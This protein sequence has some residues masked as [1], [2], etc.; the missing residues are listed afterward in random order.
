MPYA[1][2]DTAA[3]TLEVVA[4]VSGKKIRV[5]NYALASTG[6]TQVTWKS[7]STAISGPMGMVAGSTLNGDT[8]EDGGLETAAGEALNLAN[9]QAVQIGGHLRYTLES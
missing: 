5:H 6:T 9:A 4:A 7:G 8:D 2:I 3:A 1:K